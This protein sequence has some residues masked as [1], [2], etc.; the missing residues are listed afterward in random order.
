[1]AVTAADD[2]VSSLAPAPFE[3]SCVSVGVH[4]RDRE[5]W[6]RAR[7]RGLGGSEVAAILGLHPYKSALE[8]YADKTSRTPAND[9]T[10]EV[11]LWGNVFEQPILHEYGRRTGRHVV[12]GG[13]LL[14]S[15]QRDSWLV[16]LDGVQ[17]D[18]A[19]PWAAGP[20]CAEVKTVGYADVPWEERIPP[21]VQVQLQHQMLVTGAT[22]NTVI[23][24]PF[25]E[26]R[27]QWRDVAPHGEFIAY[28]AEQ[29]DAFWLRV[30]EQREP[31]PDGSDSSMHALYRLHPELADETIELDE[32]AE[33]IADEVEQINVALKELEARKSLI[34]QRV[35][36]T[37][38]DE[39]TAVLDSGR[40]FTSWTVDPRTEQCS[41]CSE[42]VRT[43]AGFRAA[44]LYP[45]RKK[46]HQ[47][48]IAR[49]SLSLAPSPD[50]ARLLEASLEMVRGG[51][52]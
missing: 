15:R 3:A 49:R 47:L 13:D 5:Q 51:S 18:C 19:P 10:S 46:P 50:L 4:S 44:R 12:S 7:R 32:E 24:L 43:V 36:A 2:I 52:Q 23:W 27:L 41:H 33:A 30:L 38:G 25:P 40:Y 20:G 1:M 9:V 39:K 28:L 37:L 8:V 17:L 22:W 34:H 21:H 6:L 48:P 14:R 31:D 11:A 26:R 16:T 35:M 29:C 45:K 42:V